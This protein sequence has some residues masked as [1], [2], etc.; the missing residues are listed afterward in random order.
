MENGG[1]TAVTRR[2]IGISGRK[3]L[4]KAERKCLSHHPTSRIAKA[5]SADGIFSLVK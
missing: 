1:A 3:C 2:A 4:A 5:I